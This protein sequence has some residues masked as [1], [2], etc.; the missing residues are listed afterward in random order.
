[1][2]HVVLFQLAVSLDSRPGNG[3]FLIIVASMYELSA[4]RSTLVPVNTFTNFVITALSTLNS[5]SMSGV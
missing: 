2:E 3:L 4:N 1:M 5:I